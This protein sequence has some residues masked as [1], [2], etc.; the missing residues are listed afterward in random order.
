VPPTPPST[1]TTGGA[2]TC[3]YYKNQELDD[4]VASVIVPVLNFNWGGES[5]YPGVPRNLWSMRCTSAQYFS[6]SGLYQF[7]AQVDDGVRLFVDGNS[8]I[9]AWTNHAGTTQVGTANLNAGPHTITVEYYQFGHDS[10]LAV[11][12]NRK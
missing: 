11:W 10:L 5:P 2:W 4:P 9:S 3:T 12:W 1:G 8:V 6:S 7:N